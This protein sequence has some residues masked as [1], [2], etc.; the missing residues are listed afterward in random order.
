MDLSPAELKVGARAHQIVDWYEKKRWQALW[1]IIMGNGAIFFI[2][3]VGAIF[4]LRSWQGRLF[5]PCLFFFP[6]FAL[7]GWIFYW[8]NIQA[9]P[10]SKL[11]LRLLEEK[12]GSALPWVDER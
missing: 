4:D 2:T 7:I 11:V 9:Y 8:I 6:A 3:V 10:A 1:V 5:L 12:Y